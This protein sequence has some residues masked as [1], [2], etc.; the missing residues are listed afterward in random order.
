MVCISVKRLNGSTGPTNLFPD[1][2]Y[3]LLTNSLYGAGELIG[4]DQ[5][6]KASM[7]F[8]AQYCSINGFTWNGVITD[9]LNLREWIFEN[10]AYCL[11]DFTIV[12]GKFSLRPTPIVDSNGKIIRGGKPPISALF[13][14]G[15]IRDLKVVFLDPEERKPF[16]AV[17]LYREDTENGFPETRAVTVSLSGASPA[18]YPEE[19]GSHE[20]DPEETFDMTQ[21][22]TVKPGAYPA[23]PVTFA[24]VAI[25][26]RTLVTHSV[27]F[28]T[29]P[30]MAMGLIPGQY[31][32]LVSE[33][34]HTSRFNN[35]AVSDDGVLT[36]TTPLSNGSYSIYYWTPGTTDVQSGTL[37][38]SG[39]TAS[40]RGIIYTLRNSTTEDRIYKVESL[41]YA[42]DGLVELTGSHVPLVIKGDSR[43]PE[44]ALA[45]MDDRGFVVDL[46]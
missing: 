37:R 8:A 40:P 1:I 42:E 36:S 7:A 43:I 30:E 29:T 41:T 3:D 45:I 27:T 5:V 15:N 24:Q 19:A 22:C 46:A 18:L 13:T 26:T 6:D 31:F 28:Q 2:V 38:V 32:R 9:R 17:C 14:D 20:N 33:A 4:I 25:R 10:A 35:G 12:G 39:N 44:G 34:T 23:H 16:K 11:L 21:F